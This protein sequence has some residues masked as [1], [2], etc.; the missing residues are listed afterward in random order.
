MKNILCKVGIH[1]WKP[2]Y[3]IEVGIFLGSP[4][5]KKRLAFRICRKCGVAEEWLGR[6]PW[7]RKLTKE[8]RE[9]LMEK[10][11]DKGDYFVLN[12]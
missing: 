4:I 8:E 3:K 2:V 10:I 12:Y 9:I 7:Y 5:K 1:K 11:H 6:F